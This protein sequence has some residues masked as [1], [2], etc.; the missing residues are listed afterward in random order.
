MHDLAIDIR[1][2]V[3]VAH[4]NIPIGDREQMV[5]NYLIHNV[6][7]LAIQRHLLSVDTSTVPNPMLAI[8]EYLATGVQDKQCVKQ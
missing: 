2:L 7:N 4:S 6:Y 3:S 5:I 8:D 1:K